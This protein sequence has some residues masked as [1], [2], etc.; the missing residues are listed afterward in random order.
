MH[1][2]PYILCTLTLSLA[3]ALPAAADIDRYRTPDG[4][5][6]ITNTLLPPRVDAES[7]AK[8]TYGGP[9]GTPEVRPSATP[10]GETLPAPQGSSSSEYEQTKLFCADRWPD[11]YPRQARCLKRQV[12]AVFTMDARL[13]AV[14]VWTS[15]HQVLTT[16][17]P[18][19][20]AWRTCMQR[21]RAERFDTHDWVM[22]D[23]CLERQ[24]QAL[25]QFGG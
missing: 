18:A 14:G 13:R 21:W 19:Y 12:K 6:M 11:D 23:A 20:R 9:L 15:T 3:L 2:F 8:G 7:F 22:V 25:G 16:M 10:Q 5:W 17:S 24:L 4:R 1:R